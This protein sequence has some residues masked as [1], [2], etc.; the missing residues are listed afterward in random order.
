MD[1]FQKA[2]ILDQDSV[3]ATVHLCRLYLSPPDEMDE[4]LSDRANIDLASGLLSYLTQGPGWDVPEAWYF[5]AKAYGKQ[6][7]KV[8]EK[9]SLKTAL[10]LAESRGVREV[11]AALGWCL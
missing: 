10:E 1:A 4:V 3:A 9:N 11:G 8:H 6:G 7:R 5:L 2:L